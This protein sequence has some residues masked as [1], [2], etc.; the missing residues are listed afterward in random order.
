MTKERDINCC[1][2][3]GFAEFGL[4]V[5]PTDT[6]VVSGRPLTLDCVAQFTDDAGTHAAS[7]HWLKDSRPFVLAPPLKYD[8]L[9]LFKWEFHVEIIIIIIIQNFITCS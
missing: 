3:G 5:E 7:I 8:L 4:T 1:I 9:S 2:V 6:V